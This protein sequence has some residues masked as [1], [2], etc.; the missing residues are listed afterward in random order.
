MRLFVVFILTFSV[1]SDFTAASVIE[2]GISTFC[3]VD[4]ASADIDLHQETNRDHNED[5]HN[6]HCH[7][8]FGHTHSA[9][10]YRFRNVI[11]TIP[12]KFYVKYPIYKQG[13]LQKYHS[14]INR[15]PIA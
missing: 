1:L 9:L 12:F 8:H 4:F 10:N 5:S 7:C 14:E 3:E 2:I 13:K 15:P 6:H 11:K